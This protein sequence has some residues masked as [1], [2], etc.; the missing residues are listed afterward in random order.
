MNKLFSK[1]KYNLHNPGN[2]K[3]ALFVN[4]KYKIVKDMI[5]KN[6]KS[7]DGCCSIASAVIMISFTGNA[8][9]DGWQNKQGVLCVIYEEQILIFCQI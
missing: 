7:G 4:R 5:R 1:I 2:Q 3:I 9:G 6:L 8:S